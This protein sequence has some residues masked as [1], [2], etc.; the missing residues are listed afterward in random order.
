MT[1]IQLRTLDFLPAPFFVVTE[2]MGDATFVDRLLQ[3]KKITNFSVGCPSRDSSK[4]TGKDAFPDY[5]LAIQTARMRG[6]SVPLRGLLV[7]ADANG[8]PPKSF[9]T[10]AKALEEA[11]FPKCAAAY[12]IN[13]SGGFRAAVY[14]MPQ[15]GETGTLEH[16]LLRAVF[17]KSAGLEK[18]LNEFSACT[19]GLRSA[20]PNQHAKMRMSALA[21]AFCEDNPWCSSNTMW[22]D[23][24]NPVPID[25]DVFDPFS[26]FLIDFSK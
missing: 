14:L 9:T 2:G 22:S 16:I 12:E 5:F 10:V 13:E 11:G 18:C 17:K 8:N 25:S 7:V 19:G 1:F 24:N 21:A 3:F 23:P 26:Q 6:A 15:K 4:G 20:K